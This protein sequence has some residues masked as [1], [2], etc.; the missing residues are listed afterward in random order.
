MYKCLWPNCGKVLRSIVGIKRHIKTQHLGDGTDSDQRRREEDFYYTEVQVKEE[1]APESA[2]SPTFGSSPIVI[3]Q[4]LAKPEALALDQATLESHL[5]N[6]ALSQSAPSSFWHIQADHAYQALPSIQIPVSPHI[7][8]SIS[9]AAATST[10]PSLSPVRSRSLSFSEHQQPTPMLKSHLIVA[11]PPRAP[12]GTRKVRGEAKKCRKVYG[13]E[14]R[15]QW[16]TACR[17]KK[18]CQRFLD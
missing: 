18:A 12:S 1:A 17:W 16:C 13:I 4:A 6:S 10:I 3:Q 5:P 11:S 14:H 15:D 8:T 2:T 7:F 9:W